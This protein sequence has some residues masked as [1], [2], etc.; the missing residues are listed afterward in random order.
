MAN[1]NLITGID[2]KFSSQDIRKNILSHI[3]KYYPANQV[4]F[5]ERDHSAYRIAIREGEILTFDLKGKFLKAI[6]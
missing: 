5:I 6:N 4:E 2:G 1:W 3:M